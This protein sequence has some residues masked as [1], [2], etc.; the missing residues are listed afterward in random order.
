MPRDEV[1]RHSHLLYQICKQ[2]KFSK[3]VKKIFFMSLFLVLHHSVIA[4]NNSFSIWKGSA[5]GPEKMT[6]TEIA[7]VIFGGQKVIRNVTDATLNLFLPDREN[8]SGKAVIV[9]PGGGFRFLSWE[10]EGTQVA[11]WLASHGIAAFVLKYRLLNTGSTEPEFQKALQEL[12]RQIAAVGNR[13]NPRRFSEKSHDDTAL[14]TVIRHAV[15]DGKQAIRYVREHAA[16][17]SIHPHDIGIM[18]FSAG[19]MVTLGVVQQYDDTL[20]KPDFA[21]AI[22]TPWENFMVPE[23]APPLFIVAT[24]DDALSAASALEARIAWQKAGRPVEIHLFEKGGH[25]FGMRK[26]NLPCDHWIDLFIDWVERRK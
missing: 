26:Q 5:V 11:E 9:C 15:E 10:N 14:A 24:N 17:W 23:D 3:M 1:L 6:S 25:G 16:D 12:F 13:S 19:G 2:Q 22:Y 21:A 18:G 8:A 7:S 4:Q 20:C